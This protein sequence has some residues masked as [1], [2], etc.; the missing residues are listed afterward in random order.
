MKKKKREKA[1]LEAEEGNK[2]SSKPPGRHTP[3]RLKPPH[4]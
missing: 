2:Q 1:F 4:L 3:G